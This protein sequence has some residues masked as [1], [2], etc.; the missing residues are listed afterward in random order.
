MTYGEPL[1]YENRHEDT[2]EQ[3]DTLL[4]EEKFLAS[5]ESV[6][7]LFNACQKISHTKSDVVRILPEQWV[8]FD[9]IDTVSCRPERKENLKHLTGWGRPTRQTSK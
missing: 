3:P 9:S 1:P 7:E 8:D 4:L 2:P 5:V 6:E